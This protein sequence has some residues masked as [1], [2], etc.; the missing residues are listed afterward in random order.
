MEPSPWLAINCALSFRISSSCNFKLS[1]S[2]MSLRS[3]GVAATE[4][5]LGCNLITEAF[6]AKP[7]V[8]K[9]YWRYLTCR[10]ER[11][12]NGREGKECKL[13]K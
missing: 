13:R 11:E 8:E 2:A 1:S 6:L 7:R 10:K 12:G 4:A 3:A 9:V 5:F